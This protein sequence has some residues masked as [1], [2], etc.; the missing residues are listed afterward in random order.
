MDIYEPKLGKGRESRVLKY[1]MEVEGYKEGDVKGCTLQEQYDGVLDIQQV[2]NVYQ[3]ELRV[4]IITSA[5]SSAIAP[6][7]SFHLMVCSIGFWQMDILAHIQ[8]LHVPKKAF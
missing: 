6:I 1:M 3:D 7:F 2:K 8:D 5:S 4:D